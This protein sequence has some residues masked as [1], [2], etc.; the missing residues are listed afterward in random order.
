MLRWIQLALVTAGD[1]VANIARFLKPGEDS[2]GAADVIEYLLAPVPAAATQ[3][4]RTNLEG[5][6]SVR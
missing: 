3:P 4:P 1:D 2:Y 6:E 5:V